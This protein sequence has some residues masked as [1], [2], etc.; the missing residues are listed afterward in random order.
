M[1]PARAVVIG[2]VQRLII[3]VLPQERA[4]GEEGSRPVSCRRSMRSAVAVMA[5][6]AH[7]HRPRQVLWFAFTDSSSFPAA[8][9]RLDSDLNGPRKEEASAKPFCSPWLGLN[10]SEKTSKFPEIMF[11]SAR[12]RSNVSRDQAAH[13]N[14]RVCLFT[15]EHD[16]TVG[17]QRDR[18]VRNVQAAH[19]FD[20]NPRGVPRPGHRSRP[21]HIPVPSQQPES[22]RSARTHGG[23]GEQGGA[24]VRGGGGG[25]GGSHVGSRPLSGRVGVSDLISV[26]VRPQGGGVRTRAAGAEATR[27]VAFVVHA[28]VEDERAIRCPDQMGVER[29]RGHKDPARRGRGE[30]VKRRL[31]PQGIPGGGVTL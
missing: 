10:R 5:V 2:D 28:V 13:G 1:E 4:A 17:Q 23:A 9:V 14:L 19:A 7:E 20:R 3:E 8:L 31:R 27:I 6:W 11:R 15:G 26:D 18:R 21:A 16:L 30:V 24:R 25:G 29:C 22:Q 12:L